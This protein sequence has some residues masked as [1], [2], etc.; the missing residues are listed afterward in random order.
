MTSSF[1]QDVLRSA[2]HK[3]QLV[4]ASTIAQL[5]TAAGVDELFNNAISNF[6]VF[7]APLGVWGIDTLITPCRGQNYQ[8]D[9]PRRPHQSSPPG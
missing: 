2:L 3:S 1:L 7:A 4:N 9:P 5:P 8:A 6:A